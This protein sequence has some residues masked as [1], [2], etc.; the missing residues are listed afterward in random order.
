MTERFV[1]T[2]MLIGKQGVKKLAYSKIAVFGIGGVGSYVVEALARSGVGAF[3]LIDADIICESNI[4]RQLHALSSTLG[5]PKVEVMAGRIQE[6]NPSA[7]VCAKQIFY[8]GGGGGLDWDYDYVIDAID[9]ITAKISI[10]SESKKRGIPMISS[11]GT[12]NKL[13][14]AMLRVCDISETSVCPLARVMRRELNKRGI[15]G[16]KVVYSQE[17]PVAC[18]KHDNKDKKPVI[19]SV[20]FVPSVAGLMIAAEVV[21][22]LT[23]F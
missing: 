3:T 22:D 2:E 1:R 10:I 21:R 15:S 11:M 7:E 6:I 18:V 12:G 13:N 9:T 23:G 8:L 17:N 4:N 20:S 19:G 14:P 16:V 5:C